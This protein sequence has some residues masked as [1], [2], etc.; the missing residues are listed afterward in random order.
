VWAAAL[1]VGPDSLYVS[2]GDSESDIWVMDLE[3]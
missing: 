1:T 2:V 3:W